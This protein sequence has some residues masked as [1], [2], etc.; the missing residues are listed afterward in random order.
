MAHQFS[1]SIEQ[2]IQEKMASGKY[3]SEDEH[4]VAINAFRSP[5]SDANEGTD[6]V[7]V[8][9]RETAWRDS[10]SLSFLGIAV[11]PAETIML[12]EVTGAGIPWM[13]PRDLTFDEAL[14]GINGERHEIRNR[15]QAPGRRV[16]LIFRLAHMQFL[17]NETSR[18]MLAHYSTVHRQ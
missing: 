1:S 4:S 13:E 11:Q 3:S 14:R 7:A 18:D 2:L 12:V 17:P 15:Q 8:V 5:S 10:S 16:H 6:Y 9:G